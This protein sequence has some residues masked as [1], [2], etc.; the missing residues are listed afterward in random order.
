MR[1]S[2]GEPRADYADLTRI[3]E[4]TETLRIKVLPV[5]ATGFEP[6]TSAV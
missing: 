4:T 2:S 3:F 5:G 6:V 1:D